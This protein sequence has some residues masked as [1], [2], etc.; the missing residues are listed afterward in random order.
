MFTTAIA[1][2]QKFVLPA[3]AAYA[4]KL[5][6]LGGK[7]IRYLP[8]LAHGAIKYVRNLIA[9]GAAKAARVLKRII[10]IVRKAVRTYAKKIA[11]MPI[12]KKIVRAVTAIPRGI[13]KLLRV[14]RGAIVGGV[15]KVGKVVKSVATK[16]YRVLRRAWR[17]VHT[18]KRKIVHG[19]AKLL[20]RAGAI[21]RKVVSKLARIPVGVK[22]F[23]LVVARKARKLVERLLGLVQRIPPEKMERI[24]RRVERVL[25]RTQYMLS[26]AEAYA[27]R[28]YNAY[29]VGGARAA[30][31][32]VGEAY[33]ELHPQ[34]QAIAGDV[35]GILAELEEAVEQPAKKAEK[36]TTTAVAMVA[37]MVQV[38]PLLVLVKMIP[39][40]FKGLTR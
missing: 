7:A 1:L 11:K 9:R 21:A 3:V 23:V 39:L 34:L 37:P 27:R 17:A 8:Q 30:L 16:A 22:E 4:P 31:A 2:A 40:L 6:E 15:K 26:V 36:P 32:V 29:R 14:V 18:V 20:K 25:A 38:M 28:A 35:Q 10:G 13:G 33:R 12:V 5:V 19:A 24:A